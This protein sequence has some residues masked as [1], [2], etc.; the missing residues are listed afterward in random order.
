M[1]GTTNGRYDGH[2]VT[3]SYRDVPL[4]VLD[5]RSRKY[6]VS[7]VKH[8]S[9]TQVMHPVGHNSHFFVELFEK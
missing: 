4:Y 1:V 9:A 6:P 3:Q 8:P 5:L 7:Q 2:D